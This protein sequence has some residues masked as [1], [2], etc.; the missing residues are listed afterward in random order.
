MM[1]SSLVWFERSGA[2][3]GHTRVQSSHGDVIVPWS[4]TKQKI[5]VRRDQGEVDLRVF[6]HLAI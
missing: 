2:P 3:L 6:V 1:I 4:L 5:A